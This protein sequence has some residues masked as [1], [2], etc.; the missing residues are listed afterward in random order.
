MLGM[1]DPPPVCM[2][3]FAH[4]VVAGLG[5]DRDGVEIREYRHRNHRDPGGQLHSDDVPADDVRNRGR[6][7]RKRIVW[8]GIVCIYDRT[9]EGPALRAG[10]RIEGIAD[11]LI[12]RRGQSEVRVPALVGS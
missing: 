8:G 4:D 6:R 11:A 12:A 9:D 1:I 5:V 10:R 3:L 7:E 2:Y